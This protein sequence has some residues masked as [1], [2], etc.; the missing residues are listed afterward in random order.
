MFEEWIIENAND[1]QVGLFF[2][3]FIVFA[4][5][6]FV[7]P[8]R[9]RPESQRRRWF[10]NL[11]LSA[12][13]I[14]ILS[15][16]P[17]GFFAVAVWARAEGLGALNVVA[18]PAV[19]AVVATLL[20][21]AFLSFFTHYLFHKV[22]LLWRVHRVHHLDTE[23]DVSTTVR[24]HPL[25]FLINLAV[26]VP[27]LAAAG[28]VPWVVL[29][30]EILDAAVT[31]FSHANIRVPG[32]LERPLHFIIVT[33][34]LHR[35]HHSS[36]QPET[37]SNFGAVFPVWDL[38]LGTFRTHTNAPQ[39]L[40]RLGLEE[41]RDDRTNR[42]GWLLASPFFE[43]APVSTTPPSDRGSYATGE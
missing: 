7:A 16:L 31:V 37:D 40:M 12:L 6:E 8:G 18:A 25:E 11:A 35:V 19:A 14:L 23:M 13:N 33:P 15:A 3:L 29:G 4:V 26:G 21:R 2:G 41:V 1:L 42:L 9:P 24:F 38:L 10:A 27:L 36:Y 43:I 28:V 39:T 34:D 32:W 30:Y 17:V 20:V 5:V 22:P